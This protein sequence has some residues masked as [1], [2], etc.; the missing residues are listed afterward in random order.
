M[1]SIY[2]TVKYLD[3]SGVILLR[4]LRS[5]PYS[6]FTLKRLYCGTPSLI[7]NEPQKYPIGQT[8]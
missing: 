8:N 1:G 4:L 3:E 7:D 5:P 2:F 6:E